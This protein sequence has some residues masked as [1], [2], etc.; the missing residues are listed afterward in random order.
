MS[1]VSQLIGEIVETVRSATVKG[2][3]AVTET[4]TRRFEPAS[5][6]MVSSTNGS[7]TV[8]GEDRDD[9]VVEVTWRG[10]D[11][12]TIDAGRLVVRG[13]EDEPL[14]LAVEHDNDPGDVAVDLSIIIPERTT[15]DSLETVNGSITVRNAS[16]GPALSTKN[17]SI[18]VHRV[19]GPL[20]LRTVNGEITVTESS[21]VEHVETT[22]G[23]IDVGLL[24]MDEDATIRTTTGR[25]AVALDP[26]L[27]VNL[28]CET[29]VGSID[30]PILD[31]S[32]T[33]LG[34]TRVSGT[35]G[36]GGPELVVEANVGEIEVR[37]LDA[38][39]VSPA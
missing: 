28:S 18:T 26:T 38:D 27:D 5:S 20:D 7:I 15:V 10:P 37:A 34:K 4:E 36:A 24:E 32:R 33:G 29:K 21:G 17:G 23:A 25:I 1:R 11:Q 22:N 35:L 39:A 8:D 14:Q 30:V 6:L 9:I 12:S 19:D 2:N 3:W 16:G 31:R 13:G